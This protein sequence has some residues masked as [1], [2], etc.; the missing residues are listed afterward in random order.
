MNKIFAF[1]NKI[2]NSNCQ[3]T[4]NFL[5]YLIAPVVILIAG[6]ILLCTVGFNSSVD[7][8]GGSTFT[9][10]INNGG[11]CSTAQQYDIDEDYNAICGKIGAILAEENFVI[12]YTQKTELTAE[13]SFAAGDAVK[14]VFKNRS[15]D[16]EQIKLDNEGLKYRILAEFGYSTFNEAIDGVDVI[17]PTMSIGWTLALV[18]SVIFAIA[19]AA[20]YMT[21]RTKNIAWFMAILLGVVDITLT[22]ALL[23]ICR[24]P[25]GVSTAGI[26]AA[27]A[28]ASLFN[29]F[30]FYKK[31]QSGIKAGI[32]DKYTF[33]RMAD[34]TVKQLAFKKAVMYILLAVAAIFITII[35]AR[36]IRFS[37]VAV[38][39]MLISTFYTSNFI[40]PA[41]WSATYREKKISNKEKQA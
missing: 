30:C 39:L 26:I 16:A 21:L 19:A 6:I 1:E 20:V 17:E 13:G 9:L 29:F 24:V 27:T 10:Y 15:T 41:I 31:A 3:I 4:K 36:A 11:E 35:P 5:Y 40:L 14:V 34:S 37:A 8:A 22:G 38:L 32:Y 18:G 23:L 2:K 12:E 28:V 25:V 33:A 7:F